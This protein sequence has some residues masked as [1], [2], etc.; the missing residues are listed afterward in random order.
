VLA[1]WLGCGRA[2]V[3]ALAAREVLQTDEWA[4]TAAERSSA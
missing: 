3:D 1:E 2:E 4:D